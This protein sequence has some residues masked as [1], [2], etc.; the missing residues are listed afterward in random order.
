[1][2]IL[3]EIIEVSD[4]MIEDLYNQNFFDEAS[5]IDPNKLKLEIQKQMQYNWE[6]NDELY[7]DEDQFLEICRGIMSEAISDSLH[8]LVDSGHVEMAVNQNGELVYGLT[9]KPLDI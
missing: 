3:T 7:L 6:Q 8:T 1:M 9:G 5:F 4:E 2:N